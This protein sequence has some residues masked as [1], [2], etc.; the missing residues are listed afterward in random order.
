MITVESKLCRNNSLKTQ[1]FKEFQR[2][3][4]TFG[5]DNFPTHE[6]PILQDSNFL[7]I[8]NA[9]GKEMRIYLRIKFWWL[10][11]KIR[12][13]G[14]IIEI[15]IFE[16]DLNLNKI[17]SAHPISNQFCKTKYSSF[18]PSAH[19]FLSLLAAKRIFLQLLS[20]E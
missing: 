10:V 13:S 15:E 19:N 2:K 4:A 9:N 16:D 17:S 20:N 6:Q 7:I 3:P 5:S 18:S 11:L 14:G 8:S 1:Y 12:F